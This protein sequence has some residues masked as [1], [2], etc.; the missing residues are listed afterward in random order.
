MST[1]SC[2]LRRMCI[3]ETFDQFASRQGLADLFGIDFRTFS[4]I[5]EHKAKH[6]LFT[7]R[8]IKFNIKSRAYHV[9]LEQ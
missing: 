5:R 7:K 3:H 1:G 2:Y 9:F 4:C 6:H 8:K